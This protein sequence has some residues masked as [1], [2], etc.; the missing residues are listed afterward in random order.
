[1]TLEKTKRIP[2]VV[3]SSLALGLVTCPLS[4]VLMGALRQ[5]SRV[6]GAVMVPSF[7]LSAAFLLK[8]YVGKASDSTPSR[9]PL[10][11]LEIPSWLVVVAFNFFVSRIGLVTPFEQAGALAVSLLITSAV[12]TPL[13]FYR[14]LQLERR[15]SRLSLG[16]GTAAALLIIVSLSLLA[17]A[18]LCTPARFIG[19]PRRGH[20]PVGANG[21]HTPIC[22]L[23][24]RRRIGLAAREL[25]PG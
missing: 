11:L 17:V 22:P 24:T 10:L 18:Y 12:W 20:V 13:V 1:M 4:F 2:A 9:I 19:N 7:L 6:F 14:R 15:F 5:Y 3:L 21:R 25:H 8:T 23:A 16:T